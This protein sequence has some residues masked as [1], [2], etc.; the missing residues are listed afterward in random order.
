VVPTGVAPPAPETGWGGPR[1]PVDR[2]TVAGQELHD[3]RARDHARGGGLD[4]QLLDDRGTAVAS[5]QPRG[6]DELLVREA[7]ALVRDVHLTGRDHRAGR[8]QPLAPGGPDA[9][10]HVAD[11]QL[12]EVPH[13]RRVVEVT[14]PV[15]VVGDDP[16]RHPPGE[17]GVAQHDS[18]V[19]GN[20]LGV[21]AALGAH[22]FT[23]T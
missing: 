6:P 11:T 17:P 18:Y 21:G 12:V 19:L 13:D 15:E 8:A 23:P 1:R 10:P 3:P 16:H 20:A 4:H 22:G 2:A 14:L 9:L 7:F 5:T